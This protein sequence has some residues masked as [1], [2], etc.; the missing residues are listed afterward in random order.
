M[1]LSPPQYFSALSMGHVFAALCSVLLFQTP[2]L[3][4]DK[5][6]L[7]SENVIDGFG[8]PQGGGYEKDVPYNLLDEQAYV[9]DPRAA[10]KSAIKPKTMWCPGFVKWYYP[11]VFAL[12]DLGATYKLSSVWAFHQFGKPILNFTFGHNPFVHTDTWTYGTNSHAP[13]WENSWLGFNTSATGRYLSLRMLDTTTVHELV[14]YGTKVSDEITSS[15]KGTHAPP[16]MRDL[17]GVN[18]F[19]DDPIQRL[20]VAGAVREYQDWSWSEGEGDPGYPHA[21]NKF[22]PTYSSFDIDDFY[23]KTTAAGLDL[24]ECLQGRS[25][26]LS[27]GN[28]TMMKWKPAP[29]AMVEANDYNALERPSSY[30]AV[31]AHSFQTAAR[32]G[33]SK[34][35]DSLLQL[36]PGQ[37]RSTGLGTLKHIEVMN[38]VTTGVRRQNQPVNH[39]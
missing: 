16:L 6:N 15:P 2:V 7:S 28:K 9:G 24:H 35:Q 8:A 10:G 19:V 25:Y 37:R 34:V 29:N 26:F 12:V 39:P 20:D 11:Q 30:V 13:G 18:G 22:S 38:E 5:I 3:A 4:D 27:Q 14:F 17:I 33:R 36:A 32:Y 31:A 23:N 1:I 21:L